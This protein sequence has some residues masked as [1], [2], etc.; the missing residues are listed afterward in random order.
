MKTAFLVL[1]LLGTTAAFGQ[2]PAGPVSSQPQ[3]YQPPSHPGHASAQALAAER[4][5]LG[6]TNYYS[7]R[8]DTRTWDLPQAPSKSLGESARMLRKEHANLKKAR[9]VFEN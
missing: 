2:Q 3:S 8:G 1:C 4:Y 6:A 5:L 7:V 9:V